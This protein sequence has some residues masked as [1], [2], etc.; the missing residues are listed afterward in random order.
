MKNLFILGFFLTTTVFIFKWM[1]NEGE[2]VK[3]RNGIISN[4]YKADSVAF[5]N[6]NLEVLLKEKDKDIEKLRDIIKD[7]EH[8]ISYLGFRLQQKDTL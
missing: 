5:S 6:K 3:T 7:R 4:Q 8:K 1:A 2:L